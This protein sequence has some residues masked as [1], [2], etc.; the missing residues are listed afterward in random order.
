MQSDFFLERNLAENSCSGL[1][2]RRG[3]GS[4]LRK[5]SGLLPPCKRCQIFADRVSRAD[6]VLSTIAQ[7][8]ESDHTFSAVSTMSIIV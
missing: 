7:T 2:P 5:G 8:Q 6:N 4:K 1:I 3:S